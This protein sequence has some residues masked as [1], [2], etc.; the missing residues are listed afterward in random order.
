MEAREITPFLNV[1]DLPTSFDWFARLG[2]TKRWEWCPPYADA[3]T[4]G[5]IGSG[6]CEIYL[7]LD[8]QGGRG[9]DGAWISLWVDDV[10]AVHSMCVLEGLEIT[11]APEDKPWGVREMHVRHPDGHVFRVSTESEHE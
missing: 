3:P 2:W 1:A 9:D 5:A 10:D 8:G 11:A 4:F 6:K 7:C